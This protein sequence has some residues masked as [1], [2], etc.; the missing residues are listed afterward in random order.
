MIQ[1]VDAS[2]STISTTS[3]FASYFA[4]YQ[5]FEHTGLINYPVDWCCFKSAP[6]DYYNIS[7]D[8]HTGMLIKTRSSAEFR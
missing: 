6:Q 8:C 1:S 7:L 2:V 4:G 5:L 3:L